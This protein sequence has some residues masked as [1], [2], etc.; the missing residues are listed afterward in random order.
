MKD[1]KAPVWLAVL[2]F[3]VVYTAD[4]YVNQVNRADFNEV[5]AQYV[6]NDAIIHQE[7]FEQYGFVTYSKGDEL[8]L[9][10][11]ERKLGLWNLLRGTEIKDDGWGFFTVG[12]EWFYTGI[13][14]EPDVEEI[15]IGEQPAQFYNSEG[16]FKY[17]IHLEPNGYNYPIK[18]VKEDGSTYWIKEK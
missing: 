1:Y 6:S 18:A 3:V 10:S 17:F 2:V 4:W 13:V 15:L 9:V 16:N 14:I 5:V 12:P 11:F 7:T 8:Y